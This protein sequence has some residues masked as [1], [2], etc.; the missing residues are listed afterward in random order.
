M[1]FDLAVRYGNERLPR[2]TSYP[3]A[4]HF[5]EAVSHATYCQWLA[6]L[7]ER[8]MTSIY[9]HVPFC[10][11][12]CWYCGCHTTVVRRDAPI[13]E[14]LTA[15]RREIDLVTSHVAYPLS[16]HHIHFGGG[17]PTIMTPAQ[18][19][20]LAE[21]L[22]KRFIVHPDTEIAVE[23]DPRTLTSAMIL[24]LGISGVTR[25][26]L[27]VQ[28]FDPIVQ[29]AINRVQSFEETAAAT[30]RLRAAGV[31]GVNFDLIYGLPRQTV[32][33]CFD[34]V[35]QCLKLRPD[36]FSV[37]GYAHVP[38]FK[39][40]Q[41]RIDEAELPDSVSRHRQA[42]AIAHSLSEAGYRQIGL[43]HFALSQDSMVAAQLEGKLHR[44]FQGYTTDTSDVL[45]GFGA[46]A[47]GR[48]AQGYVQ[49]ESAVRPYCERV[50]RGSLA[51]AKGYAL[52]TDDRLRADI[53]ERLMCDF[54]VD[55]GE[56]C[57]RHGA[58]PE[59]LLQSAPRL[60]T[61]VADGIIQLDGLLVLVADEARYLCETSHPH[62]TSISVG[63]GE[64]I[65]AQCKCAGCRRDPISPGGQTTRAGSEVAIL[66]LDI[67]R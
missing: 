18:F 33:S 62:S 21:F 25:A 23:I 53:I 56:V 49:N 67:H 36:R 61:L 24:A 31:G 2:Y 10:R 16:V 38:D 58:T 48:L 46:T 39:K 65:A 13:A 7:P 34:T 37:F 3:T 42:T 55:L 29:R 44:N 26:S 57:G 19:E 45:I 28:S 27:G 9:L 30:E 8:N 54:Q 14:Y 59:A 32:A 17:T 35:R 41:R 52:T 63:Q 60:R 15:L 6:L 1:R 43:D 5:S 4:P 47:I 11:S 12:M 66:R 40:H 20:D 51:T 64:P 22:R 50:V